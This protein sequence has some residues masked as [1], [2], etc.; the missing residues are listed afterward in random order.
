MPG[1]DDD[2]RSAASSELRAQIR[3]HNQRYYEL[4]DPEISDAEY[5]ALVRELRGLEEQYPELVT[6]DSP[7]Q[8]VGG[9]AVGHL[10]P[11]RAP[12]ADDEPRQRV[13]RGRAAGVGRPRASRGLGGARRRATC[14]S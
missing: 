7:T 5:D 1:A 14:A 6:P 12:R 3:Y 11:G 10:R 13:R 2:V 4:D 8:Q 9:A